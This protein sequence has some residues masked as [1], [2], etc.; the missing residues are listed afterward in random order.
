MAIFHFAIRMVSRGK[1]KSAVANS[2]YIHAD[3]IKS[4][5]DGKTYNFRS[6]TGVVYE[7]VFLPEEV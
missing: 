2:A 1:G 6:K 4:E 7:N 3:K 5:Y